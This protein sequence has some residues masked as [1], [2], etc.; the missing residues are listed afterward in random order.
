MIGTGNRLAVP[1]I[2]KR[3]GRMK[4]VWYKKATGANLVLMGMFCILTPS[5]SIS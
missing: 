1:E 2:R 4:W 5:V 3:R